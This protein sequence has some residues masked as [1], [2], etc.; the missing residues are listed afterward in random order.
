MALTKTPTGD[1]TKTSRAG[2]VRH[3]HLSPYEVMKI[4][5]DAEATR[6]A[7]LNLIGV[8]IDEIGA[9]DM[10]EYAPELVAMFVGALRNG[11]NG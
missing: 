9:A 5:V 1:K 2:S 4:D 3:D 11:P 10:Q 7:M 8:G 6:K